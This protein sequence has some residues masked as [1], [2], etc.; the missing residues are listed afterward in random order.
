MYIIYIANG[1]WKQRKSIYWWVGSTEEHI[2]IEDV[3]RN[4]RAYSHQG[5]P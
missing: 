5:H 3:S 2:H 4:I 1:H